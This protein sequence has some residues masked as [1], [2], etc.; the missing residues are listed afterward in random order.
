MFILKGSRWLNGGVP[1]LL[2]SLWSLRLD[3]KVLCEKI[4]KIIALNAIIIAINSNSCS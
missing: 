4:G 3:V 2:K 1:S